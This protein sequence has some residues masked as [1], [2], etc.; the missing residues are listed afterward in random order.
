M[1][2]FRQTWTLVLKNI[3]IVLV[4][5]AFSTPLRCFFLPVIFTIFLA[6]SRN[7]FVPPAKFGVGNPAPVRSLIDSLHAAGGG[8]NKVAFVNNGLTNGD[9][10]KVINIVANDVRAEGKIVEILN[11]EQ[12]LLSSCR[13]SLRGYSTCYGAAIFYSS[14]SEGPSAMWNYSLRADGGLGGGT[15]FKI[16]T[17]KSNNDVEI[18]PIPLQHAIDFA[19]A[20]LNQT[21]D[22]S[23]LPTQINEFP[24]TDKNQKEHEDDIRRRYTGGQHPR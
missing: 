16:D 8:R 3:L 10:A 19:I 9:I 21:I 5:H 6:Y 4:R 7:L 11:Q 18:Y 23:A 14:P 22:Q 17:T 15:G 2:F 12:D 13:N 20:S 24:F 1:P